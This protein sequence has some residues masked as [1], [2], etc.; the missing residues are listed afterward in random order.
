MTPIES[1]TINRFLEAV[2]DEI[3]NRPRVRQETVAAYT[4]V[5]E[6]LSAPSAGAWF[7]RISVASIK[8]LP[9]SDELVGLARRAGEA[10]PNIA[11]EAFIHAVRAVMTANRTGQT[12]LSDDESRLLALSIY[13]RATATLEPYPTVVLGSWIE[14]TQQIQDP[15]ALGDAIRSL[16][17]YRG[18]TDRRLREALAHVM[19]RGSARTDAQL[20]A[21]MFADGAHHLASQL[22]LNNQFDTARTLYEEALRAKPD[23]VETNN[24]YGYRLLEL[25]EDVERAIAMIETAYASSSQEPHI[26]DSLG[27][28]RYK[29]GRLEDWTDPLTGRLQPGALSLLRRAKTAAIEADPTGLT[30]AP[31]VDH[32]GD[33]PMGQRRPRRR[34][35]R[36]DRGSRSLDESEQ[37][38]ARDPASAL[39]RSPDAGPDRG[40]RRKSPRSLGGSR[41]GDRRSPRSPLAALTSTAVPY[42]S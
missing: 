4:R 20:S 36:V 39:G 7:G 40:S 41:S 17:E 14:F 23:H 16:G 31:I 8:E 3:I 15:F 21:Q 28:A 34:R 12:S 11:E 32:L 38:R 22:S 37:R 29:Q 24:S 26:I 13:D 35:P 30:T 6:R 18:P 42:P 9:T 25:G 33:A 27:W 19:F 10:L 5:F 2:A 1:E